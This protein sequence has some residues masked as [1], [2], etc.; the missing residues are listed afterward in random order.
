MSSLGAVSSIPTGPY[1][2]F[3]MSEFKTVAERKEILRLVSLKTSYIPRL[4]SPDENG[5]SYHTMRVWKRG[6]NLPDFTP[7]MIGKTEKDFNIRP[8]T[9]RTFTLPDSDVKHRKIQ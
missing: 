4:I 9:T 3:D 6:D 5:K 8:L 2:E 1:Q 7:F